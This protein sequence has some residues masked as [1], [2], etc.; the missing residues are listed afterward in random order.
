MTKDKHRII[1]RGI[2]IKGHRSH[3]TSY[4]P[5]VDQQASV[6]LP[7]AKLINA[8][9]A[10]ERLIKHGNI[11]SNSEVAIRREASFRCLREDHE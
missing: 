5:G 3:T 11:L 2:A 6:K 4:S 1:Y 7:S 8:I 9:N 10:P